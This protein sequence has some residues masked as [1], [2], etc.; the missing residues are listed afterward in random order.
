MVNIGAGR[1]LPIILL[2]VLT[3]SIA[4]GQETQVPGDEA[5][6]DG[7]S[8]AA[9]LK[10]RA[11]ADSP[12]IPPDVICKGNQ[13]T[14][15]ASNSTLGSVLAAVHACIGVQIDLPQSL[16]GSR[17]F[18][19]LGPASARDVL[20]SL[21]SESGFDYVIGSSDS[22]PEKVE[23]VLLMVRA[24]DKDT[25][26]V[27]GTERSLTPARRAWMQS[28]QNGRSAGA[29][30]EDDS[31]VG[32]DVAVSASTDDSAV[33]PTA[34]S[35]TN[36]SQAPASEQTPAVAE[37][38]PAPAESSTSKTADAGL[39]SSQ[40][41]GAQDPITNMQQLFEQRRQMMEKQNSSRPQ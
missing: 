39:N 6:D 22:N 1:V 7:A 20:T 12:P 16:A 10:A 19:Q 9:A 37:A 36:A 29:Q 4:L 14:I 23:T 26:I 2:A 24:K 35:G 21:F 34:N 28:L 31:P 41:T 3:A 25:P 13:L 18:E 11:S 8:S 17:I 40:S 32:T 30:S 33:T 38:I 5:T 15:S 27:A